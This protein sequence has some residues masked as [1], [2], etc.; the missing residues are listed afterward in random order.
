MPSG[1]AFK[2]H[3][4][5]VQV[6]VGYTGSGSPSQVITGVSQANPA[7]VTSAAH[8]LADGDV[9]RIAGVAGM[10][11]LNGNSYI[12][13]VINSSTFYLKNTNSTGYTAYSSGGVFDKGTFTAF[14]DL[15]NYAQTDA[16]KTEID[17]TTICSDSKQFLLGLRDYGTTTLDYTWAGLTSAVQVAMNG[18]NESNEIM[19]VR[20]LIG[21]SGV[22]GTIVQL[23]YVQQT[24]TNGGNDGIWVGSTTIR[25]TGPRADFT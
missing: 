7:V 10:T 16:A 22:G 2:F 13:D 20:V 14:C 1:Q 15:T 11:E 4:S 25:N 8:G 12:V 24:S 6:L 21:A 23:G 17:T 18:F 9:I 5:E 3:D 19:A